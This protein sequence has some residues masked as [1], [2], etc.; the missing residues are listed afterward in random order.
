MLNAALGVEIEV[1]ILGDK[2][3]AKLKKLR[4]KDHLHSATADRT[5]GTS[6]PGIDAEIKDAA[7]N[8]QESLAK[9][10]MSANRAHQH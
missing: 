3:E 1:Q 4:A 10:R 8:V 9:E 7:G 6:A 2:H 5:N